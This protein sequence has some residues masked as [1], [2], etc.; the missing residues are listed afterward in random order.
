MFLKN[1]LRGATFTLY[2][3]IHIYMVHI[4][5]V[6]RQN[7]ERQNIERQ[8]IERQNVDTSKRR[9]IKT[10]TIT[11]RR[12]LQNV[13]NYKKSN[14]FLLAAICKNKYWFI[15]HQMKCMC[16]Y[17]FLEDFLYKSYAHFCRTVKLPESLKLF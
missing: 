1:R 6:E 5:N 12:Q 14:F 15:G 4:Q 17:Y 11:K 7:V 10:S 8:N 13:D 9:H 16:N 2:Y 3:I